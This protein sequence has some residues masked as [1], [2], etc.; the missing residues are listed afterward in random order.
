MEMSH[1]GKDFIGIAE[2]AG[3][4]LCELLAIPANYKVLFLPGGASVQLA[5]V[6]I[7]SISN[8]G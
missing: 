6:P 7:S 8:T 1:R 2:K 5:A 4:D 3:A